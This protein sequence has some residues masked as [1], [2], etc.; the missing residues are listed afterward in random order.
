VHSAQVG[1]HLSANN[2]AVQNQVAMM[3][4]GFISRG[5]DSLT[6]VQ[7]TYTAMQGMVAKQA[8]VLSYMD[9]FLYIG[10]MFLI[11]IPFV[12]LVRGKKNKAVNLAE[13]MH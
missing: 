7:K 13:G 2:P 5:Y 8:A 11:C 12:L 3:T 1:S 6:S 10:A 4:R 9:V